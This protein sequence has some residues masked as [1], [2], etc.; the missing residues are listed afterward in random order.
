MKVCVFGAGMM[1]AGIAQVFLTAGHEVVLADVQQP[2]VDSGEL[3]IYKGL[4]FLED[5]GKITPEFKKDCHRRL[6]T[7][8]DK[9]LAADA[10]FVMEVIVERMDIKKS[11]LKELDKICPEKTIFASNTSAMSITEMAA[12]IPHRSEKFVGCH[13][14]NPAPVMKLVE[15]VRAIQTSD[16]T[17]NFAFDLMKSIGKTPIKVE[18]GP[19]FVVNR[20]LIPMMNEAISIY[21]DGLASA[22]D[23]DRAMQLGAG[24]RSGPLHTADLVGHDV[25]LAIMETIHNETGDPRYR[26]HPLLRKM[27]R[28]GWLGIKTGKGFFTYD[29]NGKE[30]IEES[31]EEKK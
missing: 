24:M 30:I 17:F 4:D 15:V 19:G 14:F 31:E 18:E 28:A 26:P 8:I 21:A 29:R 20:M 11:L 16:E 6:V 13:F 7:T 25:N 27:V 10:D 2:F 1:G 22:H 23:I 3:R 12:A 5:K 9:D